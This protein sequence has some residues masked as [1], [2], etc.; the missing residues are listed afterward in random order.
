MTDP[1]WAAARALVL[2]HGWN[3]VA[4]Q[5]LNPGMRLW[6]SDASDAVAGHQSY[7]GV[8]VVAGAPVCALE[9]LPGAAAEL[10]ADA[11][12]HGERVVFFGAGTRLE[13]ILGERGDHSVVRLGAQP[14]W[15][16]TAWDAIVRHKA[17]LRAVLH[18]WLAT[19]GLPPLGFMVTPDLLGHTEDRRVFVAERGG[20]IVGFLVA[21]PVPARDGWL[22]EQW[23]RMP[24]APN[25][26]TQLLVDAAMRAFADAGS[27]YATLGL[28]PLSPRGAEGVPVR[29]AWLRAAL[30]HLRAH[31]RRFYNFRGLEAF[32]AGLEP[33]EW[34]PVYAI[35]D[36]TRFTPPLLRGIAGVFS[37]GSPTRL[38]ARA[39][40]SA[41]AHELRTMREA[42]RASP[43]TT[44]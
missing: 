31:G 22:V 11:R 13:R 17:S 33:A 44:R 42:L 7:A 10:E 24:D 14:A 40:A 25:G 39:V 36:G 15:D 29:P 4:Y 3:A 43:R 30:G 12:A 26:T 6:F 35:A 16:P 20:A 19:R 9:R 27:R 28:S 2:R 41:A 32:K 8:R 21:T 37:G 5:I 34:E 18:A 23:P 38:M 1:R